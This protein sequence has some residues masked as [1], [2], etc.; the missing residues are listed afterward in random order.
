VRPLRSL[1][2]AALAALVVA[3][4]AQGNAKLIVG[5]VDDSLKWTT[6]SRPT[7]SI[8]RDLGLR[9]LR[10]PVY[11]Q[12]GEWKLGRSDVT[13]LTRVV[14]PAYGM[15]VVVS[16]SGKAR[17]TPRTQLARDQYCSFVRD[18]L[19]H[20]PTVNDVVIWNEPN[21]NEFWQPQFNADGSSA[22]PAAYAKLLARCYEV[23]HAYRPKVNVL[24]DTAPRGND[25][26]F[27]ASNVGHS[28][29]LF[30]RELGKA[31]KALWRGEPIFDTVGHHPYPDTSAE[32]PFVQHRSS[33]IGQGDYD[34]LVAAYDEAFRGTPQP[35]PGRGASV[36]YM[37][38]GF[39]TAV[40]PAKA[41]FY[42]GSETAKT[43]SA[44]REQGTQLVDAVRLAYCQPA[45]G[46]FFNFL[47]ADEKSLA[48]W[49]SGILWQDRT[50]KPS[51]GAFKAVVSEV[52]RRAVDCAAL[53]RR[54]L[55]AGRR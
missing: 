52:N 34:K 51:Y 38:D 54:A 30:I 35:V 36:W 25:N 16:V 10:V 17:Q 28:P 26:A 43:I 37:E 45:V 33:S 18:L 32:S 12:P 40:A 39:Q 14:V 53:K 55:Q 9:G 5:V 31:Y 44:D 47:L 46:A 22:A 42:T 27:A 11:W 49:Q 50:P 3:A 23:L 1:L 7:V 41:G 6:H 19:V 21:A 20:F 15:R 8:M 29:G 48:G 4:P 24:D 2:C 13:T